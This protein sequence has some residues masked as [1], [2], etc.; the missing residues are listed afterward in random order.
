M[1]DFEAFS[2]F[3]NQGSVAH[4]LIYETVPY[5]WLRLS[6]DLIEVLLLAYSGVMQPKSSYFPSLSLSFLVHKINNIYFMD[7]WEN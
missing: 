4:F 1:F 2:L 7:Y 5:K 3:F 6:I